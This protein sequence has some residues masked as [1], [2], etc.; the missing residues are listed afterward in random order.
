MLVYQK[1]LESYSFEVWN[2]DVVSCDN[3]LWEVKQVHSAHILEIEI[4]D[5]QDRDQEKNL[6]EAD[7][8]IFINKSINPI[9]YPH[10][11]IK[12]ADCIPLAV[13]GK[14]GMALIHAG[15]KGVFQEIAIHPSLHHIEPTLFFL[16]PFIQRCCYQVG[17]DF[18]KHFSQYP[19]A[20]LKDE[21]KLIFDLSYPVQC[22]LQKAF[23]H[24][25]VINSQRCTCC[26]DIF[27]SYRRNKTSQRNKNI[28][29]WRQ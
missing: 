27:F 4:S 18:F 1:N 14:K 6:E 29:R 11:L 16:G 19:Q 21:N 2:D 8:I 17:Q 5:G 22:Q 15:W 24:V 26:E 28:L 7:G 25:P 13:I 20:F 12:T 3:K 9:Q 23:P 10:L